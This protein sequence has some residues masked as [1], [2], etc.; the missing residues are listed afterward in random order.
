[1]PI[2]PSPGFSPI[3]LAISAIPCQ[4][5]SRNLKRAL[6]FDHHVEGEGDYSSVRARIIAGPNS[7]LSPGPEPPHEVWRAKIK[8]ARMRSILAACRGAGTPAPS[9]PASMKQNPGQ[10]PGFCRHEEALYALS[11]TLLIFIFTTPSIV[12]KSKSATI[13]P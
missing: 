6:F 10:C 12:V 7:S 11:I 2:V 1:V 8:T 4:V 3:L 9:P 5:A 13:S